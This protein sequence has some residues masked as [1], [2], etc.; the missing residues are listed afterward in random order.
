ME[1]RQMLLTGGDYHLKIVLLE[2]YQ[3]RDNGRYRQSRQFLDYFINETLLSYPTPITGD[4][5]KSKIKNKT[6]DNA[7]RSAYDLTLALALPL[8]LPSSK[9]SNLNSASPYLATKALKT[10]KPLKASRLLSFRRPCRG[11]R[12]RVTIP[13]SLK[14]SIT[15]CGPMT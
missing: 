9:R 8:I 6:S 11:T 4:I 3:C 13:L 7:Q 10:S 15:V 14:S 12:S 5:E 2:D 1:A